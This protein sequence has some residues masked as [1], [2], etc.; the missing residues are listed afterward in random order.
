MVE[1]IAQIIGPSSAAA[2]ALRAADAHDG[3]VEFYKDGHSWI[4]AKLP[5]AANDSKAETASAAEP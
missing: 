5:E 4:V 3:P 2:N 1:R